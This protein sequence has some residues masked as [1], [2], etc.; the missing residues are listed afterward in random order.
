MTSNSYAIINNNQINHFQILN[1][2]HIYMSRYKDICF[3]NPVGLFNYAELGFIK[4]F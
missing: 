2:P 1:I 4:K 3:M